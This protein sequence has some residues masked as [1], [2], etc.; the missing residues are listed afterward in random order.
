[1]HKPRS[2]LHAKWAGYEVTRIAKDFVHSSDGRQA[3]HG[4]EVQDLDSLALSHTSQS[5]IEDRLVIKDL[6]VSTVLGVNPWERID[7]QVVRINLTVLTGLERHSSSSSSRS[8]TQPQ[9]YRTIVRSITEHVETTAYQTVESLALSIAKVAVVDNGV[10]KIKVRVDKPS[11][12]MF[13]D[14][15]GCEVERERSFFLEGKQDQEEEASAAAS[16]SKLPPASTNPPCTVPAPRTNGSASTGVSDDEWH[17]AVIAL[18]SNIGNRAQSIDLAVKALAEDSPDCR[19][20]DTSFLYETAPMYFTKQPKFLNGACRIATRLSPMA[21]LDFTQSIELKLGRDKRGVPIK[22]PRSVDLDLVFYDDVQMHNERLTIPHPLLQ[23]REFVLRPVA[24]LVPDYRHPKSGRSV[25]NQ[26]QVLLNTPGYEPAEVHRVLPIPYS[27]TRPASPVLK[28]G[29]TQEAHQ[30]WTWGSRTFIMGILNA[31]PDSFSDGGDNATVTAAVKTAQKMIDEGA[32][33]LD[34]GGMS[35]APQAPEV[36]AEEE[37]ARVV[38]VI[39]AIRAAGITAPI[40]ID[41]FRAPVAEAALVAGANIINDVS[42]G[43][44][45]PAILDVACRYSVPYILMHT[46]GDSKTMSSMTDYSAS[47]GVVAG[48]A[49]ELQHKVQRALEAGVKRWNLILDPG[50][51]FAKNLEGNLDLLRGLGSLTGGGGSAGLMKKDGA[52]PVIRNSEA[53]GHLNAHL[54]LARKGQGLLP[55]VVGQS[56]DVAATPSQATSIHAPSTSLYAFPTL[57]GTSRKRFI[58]TLLSQPDPKARVIGTASTCLVG[59]SQGVD[60]LRV[61]DVK[62]MKQVGTMGDAIYR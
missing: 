17:L 35:T 54:Q 62:E 46:R 19:L 20:I 52:V 40:S 60:V 38:P 13:A 27:S 58:G 1:M 49:S 51:G 23:E 26:L 59:I 8:L 5:A 55:D 36:S 43:D 7:K 31:T 37:I 53:G 9:D 21:L 18:G 34:V 24:D 61:H 28:E 2:L 25:S 12:I 56:L 44:R 3:Q 30:H 32:D 50:V 45:D 33:V 15:A 48:V 22:G 11:A 14:A 29:S 4:D 41:T 47:G 10:E 39:E 6:L 57:L 42:G 16:T